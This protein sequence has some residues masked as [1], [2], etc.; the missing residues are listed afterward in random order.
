MQLDKKGDSS[1][2]L[3]FL[4][5]KLAMLAAKAELKTDQDKI[6][7]LQA[8]DSNDFSAKSNFVYLFQEIANSNCMMRVLNILLHLVIL[9]L[10]RYIILTLKYE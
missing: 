4:E 1:R 8:I 2:S 3:L 6:V 5:T 7:K 9:L 10:Q